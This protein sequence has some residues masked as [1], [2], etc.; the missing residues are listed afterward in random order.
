MR[1]KNSLIS[2]KRN[3]TL[4]F[5]RLISA[6]FVILHH[7]YPLTGNSSQLSVLGPIAVSTF[8][9]ISGYLV[10]Q[11]WFSDPTP[12]IFLWKRI[13]RI[14][15]GLFAMAIF[16]ITIIGPLNTSLPLSEYYLNIYTWKYLATIF[17]F[18]SPTSLPGVF[19][20]NP[21]PIAVNGSIWTIPIEFRMYILLCIIGVIGMLKDRKVLLSIVLLS[22]IIYLNILFSNLFPLDLF[23]R[24]L[25][26]IGIGEFLYTFI[27]NGTP[28]GVP[29]YN[30][31]FFIGTL[32]YLYE[33]RIKFRFLIALGAFIILLI[34][35]V[36]G[37]S[38]FFIALLLCLPYLVL[39]LGQLPIKQLCNIGGKYGDYSYGL[40]IYAFPIQQTIAHFIPKIS[41]TQ[42]FIFSLP[43]TFVLSFISWWLIENKALSL[44]KIDIL[45]TFQYI[46]LHKKLE[47]T[48]D[49]ILLTK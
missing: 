37:G 1:S 48:T 4:D 21:F 36:L 42:M 41:P 32:F 46:F 12:S 27:S 17:I 19:I 18:I 9:V 29:A 45:K 2:F 25:E 8:F 7:S 28:S 13:L 3:N 33:D 38:Y 35:C 40:Y 31:I 20:S 14:V 44:K 23:T 43:S 34:T 5:L 26:S 10:S 49:D 6:I 47:R 30:I 15:P 22:F 16:T 24:A 39:Y 11:S